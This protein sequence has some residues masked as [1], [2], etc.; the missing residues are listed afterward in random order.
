MQYV[1]IKWTVDLQYIHMYT[2][3]LGQLGNVNNY[4]EMDGKEANNILSR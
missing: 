4:W 2:I 1:I 3:Y